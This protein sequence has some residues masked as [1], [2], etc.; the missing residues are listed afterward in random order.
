MIL[1]NL[2]RSIWICHKKL[3]VSWSQSWQNI[4]M[5]FRSFSIT[6]KKDFICTL[7]VI[8]G[9]SHFKKRNNILLWRSLLCHQKGDGDFFIIAFSIKVVAFFGANRVFGQ[10]F[11]LSIRIASKTSIKVS[12]WHVGKPKVVVT[13]K[14][15]FDLF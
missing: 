6:Y 10:R 5:N 3:H 2:V 8:L 14:K 12:S 1:T 4:L 7:P 15:T 9:F 13:C 11:A